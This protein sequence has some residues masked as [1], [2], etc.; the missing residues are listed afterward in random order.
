M[1]FLFAFFLLIF[2]S[3]QVGAEI[4]VPCYNLTEKQIKIIGDLYDSGRLDD[5]IILKLIQASLKRNE[6]IAI[7]EFIP[8]A[9]TSELEALSH[10]LIGDAFAQFSDRL[11]YV[12]DSEKYLSHYPIK[13][14]NGENDFSVVNYARVNG[15]LS[16]SIDIFNASLSL[17]TSFQ[18]KFDQD[19]DEFLT[20]YLEQAVE[21][22]F[23]QYLNLK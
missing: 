19:K 1:K 13:F 17:I 16:Y 8:Q 2:T 20:H 18:R 15:R 14:E 23:N 7:E 21:L 12:F 5:E 22:G 9:T 3:Y 10:W 11:G 4:C 6:R